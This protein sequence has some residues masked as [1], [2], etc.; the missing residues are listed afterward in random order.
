MGMDST[1]PEPLRLAFERLAGRERAASMAA[2]AE[3][4]D[5]DGTAYLELA[6]PPFTPRHLADAEALLALLPA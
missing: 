4:G 6:Q 1:G 5:D 3:T 2:L